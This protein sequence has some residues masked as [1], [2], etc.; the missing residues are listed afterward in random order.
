VGRNA[1]RQQSVQH[2]N[3][4]DKSIKSKN[5]HEERLVCDAVT[6]AWFVVHDVLSGLSPHSESWT[7]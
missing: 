5:S 6:L 2:R 7:L 4:P 1:K 3:I